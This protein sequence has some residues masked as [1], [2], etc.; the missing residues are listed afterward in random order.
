[1]VFVEGFFMLFSYSFVIFVFVCKNYILIKFTQFF[2]IR[3]FCHMQVIKPQQVTS[4]SRQN[5]T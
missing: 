4:K 1:M 2:L 3:G 5:A